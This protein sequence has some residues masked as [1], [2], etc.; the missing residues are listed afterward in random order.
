M[1]LIANKLSKR[2]TKNF[3]KEAG[4]LMGTK[5]AEENQQMITQIVEL[6]ANK[7]NKDDKE[8]GTQMVKAVTDV[9]AQYGIVKN[10]DGQSLDSIKEFLVEIKER[11]DDSEFR[12]QLIG[13][14]FTVPTYAVG[15]G[16][17][18]YYRQ[19]LLP[20]GIA[21]LCEM[22]YRIL[23]IGCLCLSLGCDTWFAS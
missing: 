22:W 1:E 5:I 12:G 13:W 15:L 10:K 3:Q 23:L 11:N 21:W 18:I 7:D 4:K 2:V 6:L 9:L 14:G 20:I 16:V 8:T 17:I 19:V